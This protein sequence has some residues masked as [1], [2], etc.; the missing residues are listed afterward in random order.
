METSDAFK[1]LTLADYADKDGHYQ[2]ATCI[3]AL[4]AAEDTALG[5]AE[6]R[7]MLLDAAIAERDEA[8]SI[9]REIID[10]YRERAQVS[11]TLFARARKLLEGKA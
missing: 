1:A 5:K 2:L 3:R 4:V 7:K 6:A 9:L 11:V 8:L 10:D